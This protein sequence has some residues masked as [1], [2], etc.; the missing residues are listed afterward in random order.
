MPVIR[1]NS[2]RTL[3]VASGTALAVY[4]IA[5]FVMTHLPPEMLSRLLFNLFSSGDE[6]LDEGGD[7]TMHFVAYAGLAFLFTS[8]LWFRGVEEF[9][10]WKLTFL[11][12][13]S[14]AIIDELLQIPFR[15]TADVRDC[16]ADWVG[17]AIG[18]CCFLMARWLIDRLGLRQTPAQAE[19][20]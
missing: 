3:L 5:L 19:T 12:L 15:R 20:P 10:R 2:I 14:Y 9:Q 11:V 4:W 6:V 17:V 16:I 13:G 8:F 18:S 7:K 1:S